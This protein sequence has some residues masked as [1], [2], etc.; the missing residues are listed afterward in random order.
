MASTENSRSS[1]FSLL[2]QFM[3][4]INIWSTFPALGVPSSTWHL[5]TA[6][7]PEEGL[8]NGMIQQYMYTLGWPSSLVEI[9]SY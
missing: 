4:Q 5:I 9:K 7:V 6:D 2:K 1:A 3:L 8:N